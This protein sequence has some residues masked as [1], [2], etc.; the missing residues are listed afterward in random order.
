MS[1]I[2]KQITTANKA[3]PEVL[4]LGISFNPASISFH[5]SAVLPLR[6]TSGTLIWL[7]PRLCASYEIYSNRLFYVNWLCSFTSNTWLTMGTILRTIIW[8][9]TTK[10]FSFTSAGKTLPHYCRRYR[11][12]APELGNRRIRCFQQPGGWIPANSWGSGIFFELY[13]Q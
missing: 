5:K 6:M 9:P 7:I 3:P 11:V 1:R 12:S 2:I 4:F 13:I 8:P 10:F